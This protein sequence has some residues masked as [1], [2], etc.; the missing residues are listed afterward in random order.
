MKWATAFIAVDGCR[1]FHGLR[2]ILFHDPG[3]ALAKPRSTPGF[4]LPPAFAGSAPTNF[5][6]LP[7]QAFLQSASFSKPLAII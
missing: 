5:R 1:P 4:M 3:V 6:R 2:H 7:S